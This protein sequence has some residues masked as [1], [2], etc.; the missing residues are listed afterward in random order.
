[1]DYGEIA[2]IEKQFQMGEW[3]RFLKS[4]SIRG[5][6][7]WNDQRIDFN[8]PV[9]AIVGEN[10]TGKS[11][12]LKVAACAYEKHESSTRSL[13]PSDFFLQTQWDKIG[14]VLLSYQ[15]KQGDQVKSYTI[16][17]P[18]D[19]W[20]Y[21]VARPAN[22]VYFL[23]ISRTVPLDGTIGYAKLAK[24]ATEEVSSTELNEDFRKR[25]SHI[26]GRDYHSARF[27]KSNA[28]TEREV[29]L[30]R[31]S[32]GEISQFHQ[33]A[34]EDAMLDLARILQSLPKYSLLI[35]DE[36]ENSLHPR[37]QRRLTRFLLWLS[38]QYRIQVILSTHSPYVLEELPAKARILLLPS[39]DEVKVFTGATTEFALSRLDDVQYPELNIFVEDREA[40]TW[41]CKILSTQ[42]E[43]RLLLSRSR[44]LPAGPASTVKV[45]G[46]LGMK[47]SLPYRSASVLDGDESTPAGCGKLPG[48][49]APEVKV[50]QDLKAKN[51]A[52][53]D[54]AFNV[55]AGELFGILDDAMREPDHHLWT[56]LVG[57]RVVRSKHSVWETMCDQWVRHC[58]AP[59]EYADLFRVLKERVD[60]VRPLFAESRPTDL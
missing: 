44:V 47:E 28:D 30:L 2:L 18:N 54:E 42:A 21:K 12:L 14:S 7:G 31:S 24:L 17:K 58:L 20:S 35:I 5:L 40:E 50:F 60:R 27:A 15:I 39:S 48:D 25:L 41:L 19:R 38:R 3:P 22:P 43:G 13:F 26:L 52:K 59:A 6:R 16:A 29:G 33:G 56:T 53:L 36:V 1:M 49:V 57:N 9:C 23:D 37:A 10:G 34:G 8:F 32:I 55:G 11:T 4:L 45:L 51:W 46:M